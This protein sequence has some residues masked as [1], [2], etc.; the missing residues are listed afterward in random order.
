MADTSVAVPTA[1][2]SAPPSAPGPVASAAVGTPPQVREHA[3]FFTAPDGSPGVE[4]F[5]SL[6]DAVARVEA[7]VNVDVRDAV[8][9]ALLPVPLH[10]RQ[11]WRVEVDPAGPVAAS[12]AVSSAPAPVLAAAPTASSAPPS[13]PPARSAASAPEP[14]VW[15]SEP[16]EHTVLRSGAH[17][18]SPLGPGAAVAYA[19]AER[20][21][22]IPPP[23]EQEPAAAS[24][25]APP[26]PAQRGRGIGFFVH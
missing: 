6:P 10:V 5:A 12:G 25:V 18:L 7:L 9:F 3:V 14:E 21:A 22:A 8:V 20:V 19:P 26:P 4:R 17:E 2:P 23:P 15:A 24:T 13:A 1:P 16:V 11:V